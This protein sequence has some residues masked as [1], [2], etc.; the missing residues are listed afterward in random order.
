[1]SSAALRAADIIHAFQSSV[2]KSDWMVRFAARPKM[3]MATA[4]TNVTAA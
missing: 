1:M 4:M 2:T 3:A